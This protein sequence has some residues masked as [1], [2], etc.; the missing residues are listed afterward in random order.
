[1]KSLDLA[2]RLLLPTAEPA[3]RPCTA[4]KISSIICVRA[5][6]GRNSETVTQVTHE[7]CWLGSAATTLSV[8]AGD[9][10]STHVKLFLLSYIW[11][12]LR[13]GRDR[14]RYRRRRDAATNTYSH[15]LCLLTLPERLHRPFCRSHMSWVC[16]GLCNFDAVRDYTHPLSQL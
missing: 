7:A 13:L 16:R 6:R 3:S 15:R 10:M 4:T 8:T 2:T 12:M 11:C 1:M 5:M 9:I 14:S